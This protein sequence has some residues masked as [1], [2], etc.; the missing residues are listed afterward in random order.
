MKIQKIQI[1]NRLIWMMKNSNYMRIQDK[2][3]QGK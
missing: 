1:N 2:I 3:G